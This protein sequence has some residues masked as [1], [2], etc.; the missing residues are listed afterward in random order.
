MSSTEALRRAKA[1]IRQLRQMT[2]ARGCTEAEAAAAMRKVAA[3]MREHGLSAADVD[4]VAAESER[5]ATVTSHAKDHLWSVLA[6]C[7]NTCAIKVHE[8]RTIRVRFYGRDPWPLV[9]TYIQ[10]VLD[11]A[12]AYE[13]R[14]FQATG[15]YRLKRTRRSRVRSTKNFVEAMV[16]RLEQTVREK[17]AHN[18]QS[19]AVVE[20]SRYVDELHPDA[21]KGSGAK[22]PQIDWDARDKGYEAG[23]RV[24]ISDGLNGTCEPARIGAG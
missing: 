19:G 13:T 7:T 17:F 4:M 22:R 6:D 23:S 1:L 3:L 8:G 18:R 11:R 10:D 24:K 15:R 2:T 5:P 20:A 9:A 16:L 21:V 14:K 12:I